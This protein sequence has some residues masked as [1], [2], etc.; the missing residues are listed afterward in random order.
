MGV[1]FDLP[2]ISVYPEWVCS[3]TARSHN[4][5]LQAISAAAVG[6]V[7]MGEAVAT[8]E[9]RLAATMVS[10][11]ESRALLASCAQRLGFKEHG[12]QGATTA[13]LATTTTPIFV[14]DRVG[15][16]PATNPSSSSLI[17][18]HRFMAV[19]ALHEGVVLAPATPTRCSTFVLTSQEGSVAGARVV[20]I[21]QS[22]SKS[23]PHFD[24]TNPGLWRVQCLQY[25]HRFNISKCLWV[26]AARMHMDGEAKEW[27]EAY[28]L[29]Q[30]V[31][32]WSEFMDA[33]EAHFGSRDFRQEL[34]V[35]MLP[36]EISVVGA[37]RPVFDGIQIRPVSMVGEA[38]VVHM[39]S[40]DM[41][42]LISEHPVDNVPHDTYEQQMVREASSWDMAHLTESWVKE[43][44]HENLTDIGS[45]S[46]FLEHV[47]DATD[48]V[49]DTLLLNEVWMSDGVLT[50]VGGISIFLELCV[51]TAAEAFSGM[52][53]MDMTWD[54][55]IHDH[56][57]TYIGGLLFFLEL[58][59]DYQEIEKI[60]STT[61]CMDH[62]LGKIPLWL[63]GFSPG[64]CEHQHDLHW[65]HIGPYVTEE[66]MQKLF[67][68]ARLWDL[69]IST[70]QINLFHSGMLPKKGDCLVMHEM[71]LKCICLSAPYIQYT[72][73]CLLLAAM[74][75]KTAWT[76][77]CAKT[78]NFYEILVERAR[79]SLGQII[80]EVFGTLVRQSKR[81]ITKLSMIGLKN[82]IHVLLI[83]KNNKKFK[84]A[85]HGNLQQ[86]DCEWKNT[87]PSTKSWN[88]S[89]KHYFAITQLSENFSCYYDVELIQ[90]SNYV[91][92]QNSLQFLASGGTCSFG[93]CSNLCTMHQGDTAL[94]RIRR[95]AFRGITSDCTEYAI[96][97]APRSQVLGIQD[98][99][100]WTSVAFLLFR[101]IQLWV[102]QSICNGQDFCSLAISAIYLQH[103]TWDPG[104]HS[105]VCARL[106]KV[107]P[108][109]ARDTSD[110]ASFLST[111]HCIISNYIMLRLQHG[112]AVAWGQAT[113]CRGGSVTPIIWPCVGPGAHGLWATG[114]E[115][116]A[117]SGV[118][119]G[120]D[121]QQYRASN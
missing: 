16:K 15:D 2:L 104:V 97:M 24:G 45:S 111:S 89:C 68:I 87:V 22:C 79:Y 21:D 118:Y 69:G 13:S 121:E 65:E 28:K 39:M 55:E 29:R 94:A 54:M 19:G 109:R 91:L 88:P 117:W 100:S 106:V 67:V 57:L 33:V 18:K 42:E 99:Y 119:K 23:F 120:E 114:Q 72:L 11:N 60:V 9:E 105:S 47:M 10:L 17:A 83:E 27:F 95:D 51:H 43:D 108:A 73:L 48:M 93:H 14:Q 35:D 50:H 81:D 40:R 77:Q 76:D 41:H 6:G 71:P 84:H 25:F 98:V 86:L 66:L 49:C 102:L 96:K 7:L 38:N 70:A 85:I 116:E 115:L 3:D 92:V 26:I 44:S 52:L 74:E 103:M 4:G 110:N 101:R 61:N 56:T 80:H 1:D 82:Q 30:V 78:L 90:S 58:T 63:S 62:M 46:L 32:D 59:I 113:F 31:G 36:S 34:Q 12:G 107:T 64:T 5:D 8:M 53:P 37:A 20:H 112:H 75:E